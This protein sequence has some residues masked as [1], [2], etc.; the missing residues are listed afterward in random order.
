MKKVLVTGSSGLL[1]LR[2]IKYLK[3]KRYKLVKF[4]RN[5]KCDLSNFQ[6]CKKYLNKNN[7]DNIINLSA[8]TDIDFCEK[9]KS[10]SKKVNYQ[11]VSNI[12][13]VIKENNLNTHLI[14]IS[15]DQFYNNFK[16][17]NENNNNFK[18]FYTK[19]KLLAENECKKINSTILRTN[20]S[21]KSLNK[22]RNSFSDWIFKSLQNKKI[23]NL[24]NDIQFSPLSIKSLC[25]VLNIILIKRYNGKY[26]VGS[27]NGFSK[28]KFAI[29][30]A[31]IL[32]L[33]QKLIKKVTY[34]D[35]NFFAKRN[36]DMRMKVSKFEKKFNVVL[37]NLDNEIKKI[38]LEYKN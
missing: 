10:F 11:I 14:Q 30:F 36:K 2:L 27:K 6:Y 4:K 37:P 29:K 35:I 7:F 26:N 15:T 20:F 5:K 17:N 18:N 9:N 34:N 33:D 32:N 38:S 21:G 28:Y 31:E 3:K 25:D 12:C 22:K 16:T 24:A 19:T 1:G 23:I 8:I 13:K